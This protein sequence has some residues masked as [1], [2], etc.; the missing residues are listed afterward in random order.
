MKM[1]EII[2]IAKKWNIS[3]KI[4]MKKADL[5]REIQ[6][7]E[8]YTACFYRQDSCEE[9]ECLWKDDCF[10]NNIRPVQ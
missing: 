3:F 2:I 4:G 7:R 10:P 5:I 6:K 8:G 9:Q 1:Q